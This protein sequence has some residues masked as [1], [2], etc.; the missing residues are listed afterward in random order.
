[1]TDK[2]KLEEK[3]YA[4]TLKIELICKHTGRRPPVNVKLQRRMIEI[5]DNIN[6]LEII[7]TDINTGELDKPCKCE[8]E[9]E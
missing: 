3:E 7:N 8:Q 5:A 6:C 2:E 4:I 1:M 9:D